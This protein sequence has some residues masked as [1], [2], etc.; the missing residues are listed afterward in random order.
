[1]LL[2]PLCH[3]RNSYFKIFK[4]FSTQFSIWIH[5][6]ITPPIDHMGSLFSL[7]FVVFLII[8]ILTGIRWYLIVVSIC[9][10]PKISDI[11]H[12]FMYLL[13][14]CMNSLEKCLFR[15]SAHFFFFLDVDL[16]E[17]LYIRDTNPLL[18][19]SFAK[20]LLPF[21]WPFCFINS[22]AVQK[23]LSLT[24]LFL[25]LFILSYFY[26]CFFFPIVWRNISKT[27]V[28][29]HTAYIFF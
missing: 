26:F 21:K 1:M 17:S 16:Y 22:F 20:Y 2:I 18:D 15:S 28:K 5:Q 29:E 27:N 7:L 25:L 11:V 6:S 9:I 19:I 13:A 4:G 3:S 24:Y 14:I 10:S 8:P 12:L 23:L